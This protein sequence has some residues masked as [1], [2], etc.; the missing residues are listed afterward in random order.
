M[1]VQKYTRSSHKNSNKDI[2]SA[3]TCNDNSKIIKLNK[4]YK[5][6]KFYPRKFERWNDTF[7]VT[8]VEDNSIEVRRTDVRVGG[9]G[10]TLLIDVEYE[11]ENETKIKELPR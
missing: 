5:N 11:N 7:S 6:P 4:S 1:K 10:E 9:W 8:L 3:G 2:I